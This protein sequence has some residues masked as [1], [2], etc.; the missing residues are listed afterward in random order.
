MDEL[1]QGKNNF[2]RRGALVRGEFVCGLGGMDLVQDE[3]PP[4]GGG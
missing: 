3:M 2:L 1:L 4:Y